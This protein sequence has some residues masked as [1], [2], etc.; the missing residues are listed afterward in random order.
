[1]FNNIENKSD[2]TAYFLTKIIETIMENYYYDVTYEELYNAAIR[3][4]TDVLD[5]YSTYIVNKNENDDIKISNTKIGD[6]NYYEEEK[7]KYRTV[8]DYFLDQVCNFEYR[9]NNI[10]LIKITEINRNTVEELKETIMRLTRDNINKVII[11]L[12]DNMGGIVD[13]AVDICNLLVCNKILFTSCDKNKNVEIYKSN[14]LKK[15]FDEIVVLTNRKT[16]SAAEAIALSL[17]DD[18]NIIIGEKTYGKGVSQKIFNIYGGGTLNITTK[19]YFRTNG[20]SINNSGII[21]DILINSS[22]LNGN[23]KILKLACLYI[24]NKL[25]KSNA[26][27]RQY[28]SQLQ[29]KNM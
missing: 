2:Y 5:S 7:Q 27:S 8:T 3:G 6:I 25:C 24:T 4:M 21:P 11:D 23:D 14:L 28:L 13:C 18:G 19:E 20:E 10:K 26:N 15:P 17:Q 12:R 1:M 22:G 29:E 16:M 9:Y